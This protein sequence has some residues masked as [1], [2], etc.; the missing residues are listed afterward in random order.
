MSVLLKFHFKNSCFFIL[1]FSTFVHFYQVLAQQHNM[2]SGAVTAVFL[3]HLFVLQTAKADEES[4]GGGGGGG[5]KGITYGSL[6]ESDM[7]YLNTR[8]VAHPRG[9]GK[10]TPLK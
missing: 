7:L 6:S 2:Y 9:G 4:W 10:A 5:G 8:V 3:L 1:I